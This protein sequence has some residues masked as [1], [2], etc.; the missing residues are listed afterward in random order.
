MILNFPQI[1]CLESGERFVTLHKHTDGV[2]CLRFDDFM[3]VSGSYDKT[4]K[5]WDFL[6]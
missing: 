4:V 5:V 3:I 2:T 6:P 1:W